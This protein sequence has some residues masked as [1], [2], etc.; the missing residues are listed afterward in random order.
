MALL[1]AM[2]ASA[3]PTNL[4]SFLTQAL[5]STDHARSCHEHARNLYSDSVR[6]T[7]ANTFIEYITAHS[8]LRDLHCQHMPADVWLDLDPSNTGLVC[9]ELHANIAAV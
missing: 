3:D 7:T 8:W 4:L 2:H 9:T 1:F 5:I 6:H